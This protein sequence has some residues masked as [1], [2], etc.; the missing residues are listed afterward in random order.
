MRIAKLNNK[1][2]EETK[3]LI[4]LSMLSCI[5]VKVIYKETNTTVNYNSITAAATALNIRVQAIWNYLKRNQ[6]KP[7]KGRYVFEKI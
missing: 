6:V 3:A 7:H 5:K 1:L 4:S 2:S